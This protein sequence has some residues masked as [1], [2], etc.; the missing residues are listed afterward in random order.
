MKKVKI[1]ITKSKKSKKVTVKVSK[2]KKYYKKGWMKSGGYV[3]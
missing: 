3:K 2:S 1:K